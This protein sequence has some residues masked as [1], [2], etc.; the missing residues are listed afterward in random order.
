MK[1]LIKKIL[2]IFRSPLCSSCGLDMEKCEGSSCGLDMEKCEVGYI[3]IHYPDAY[4]AA[5]IH[6]L[7]CKKKYPY[8][9]IDKEN[10][11]YL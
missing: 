7:R 2:N 3:G 11:K 10:I 4:E 8:E 9:K 6:C 1:K 5:I